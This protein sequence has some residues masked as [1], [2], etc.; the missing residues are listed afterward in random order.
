MTDSGDRTEPSEGSS[1]DSGRSMPTWVMAIVAALAW[2]VLRIWVVANA[3]AP[4][5]PDNIGPWATAFVWARMHPRVDMVDLPPY[6]V[7]T[8]AVLAPIL[9]V[10]DDPVLRYRIGILVLSCIA[11]VGACAISMTV[12]STLRCGR[13]GF[14]AA[15]LVG[16]LGTSVAFTTSFTWVEP[17]AF[18][19]FGV[20]LALV[21]WTFARPTWPRVMFVGMYSGSAVL[22]HGRFTLLAP[23]WLLMIAWLEFSEHRTGRSSRVAAA[24]LGGLIVSIAASMAFA[25]WLRSSI[26]DE[27]WS[28]SSFGSDLTFVH[29]M[30]EIDYWIAVAQTGVGQA[31]YGAT[32]TFGLA[33]VGAWTLV[34]VARRRPDDDDGRRR[35]MTARTILAGSGA[36]YATSVLWIAPA[37]L[38]PAPP[39][40][41]RGRWDH[42]V[43]G[44]YIDAVAIALA[45]FG[46]AALVSRPATA[47]RRVLALSVASVLALSGA[48]IVGHAWTDRDLLPVNRGSISGVSAFPVGSDVHLAR[49]SALGVLIG[50]L[51]VIVS[52]RGRSAS[53]GI[54][55]IVMVASA[56]SGSRLAV[57]HLQKWDSSALYEAVPTAVTQQRA[58]VAADA[59]TSTAFRFNYPVQQFELAPSNWN[60]EISPLDS[61]D[62]AME[63]PSDAALTVMWWDVAPA[64]GWCDVG[65][66][67]SVRVWVARA[68][69][70][71]GARTD[72]CTS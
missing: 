19:Y 44:R 69:L 13:R 17:A 16:A 26:V 37:L 70:P 23:I 56:A 38:D 60:F 11:L 72:G 15:M 9:L 49:W 71:D 14:V 30:D 64:G 27:A 50:S 63:L 20:W 48:I 31:W 28:E 33:L 57:E 47:S 39:P 21:T 29:E 54:L 67:G 6:S 32:S 61:E 52:A 25:R 10:V 8:G 34:R 12:R 42:L 36:I 7:G 53:L 62:L 55:A 65:A 51:V 4:R 18:A 45:S 5:G 24:T 2:I 46:A 59:L 58:V 66:Y 1:P 22:I 43:H 41:G 3:E 68:L 40:W 35:V